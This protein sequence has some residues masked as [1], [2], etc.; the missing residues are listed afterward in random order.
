MRCKEHNSELSPVAPMAES[1]RNGSENGRGEDEADYMG[2]L[3]LLLPPEALEAPKSSSR[4]VSLAFS[5]L[6]PC[7]VPR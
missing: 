5:S 1:A 3:S 6:L 7:L 2:D 4:K